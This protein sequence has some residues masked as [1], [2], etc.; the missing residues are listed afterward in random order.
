LIAHSSASA[1]ELVKKTRSA[2]VASTSRSPEPALAGDLV[3]IGDVPEL[4]GLLGQGGD[5]M[6]VAMAERIDGDAGREVQVSLARYRD[7]ATLPRPART[8][9]ARA[10]MPGKAP[11]RSSFLSAD[12]G[13]P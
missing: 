9:G 7:R 3:E 2:N 5:Q 10:R 12:T 8:P 11:N 1:P 13:R 6:R 4:A